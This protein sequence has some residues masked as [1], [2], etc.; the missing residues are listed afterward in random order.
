MRK[1]RLLLAGLFVVSLFMASFL[2]GAEKTFATSWEQVASAGLEGDPINNAI[3]RLVSFNGYLY[4]S[5]TNP[6]DGAKVF[7]SSNGTTWTKVSADGF[8][9]VDCTDAILHVH[10]D[11]IYAGTVGASTPCSKLYKSINGTTWTQVGTDGFGDAGND[12]VTSMVTFNNQL[13]V[14]T[15]NGVTGTEI[16]RLEE[17]GTLT[18]V[19]SDGFGLDANS[20]TWA[21]TIFGGAIYAGV[22]QSSV[23]GQAQIWKSL[24]GSDWEKIM[25]GGFG[26][27]GNQRITTFFTFNG[28]LYAGLLNAVSG[29][30][31]WRSISDTSWEQVNGDG[32]G[33]SNNYWPG[34][35][36]AIINGTIYV[37]VR[38]DV[39]G[40]ELYLSTNG[41]TWTQEGSSGFGDVDNFALY[42]ITFD[43][44]IYLGISSGDGVEIWRTGEMGTLSLYGDLGEGTVGE[45]YF[46]A[47]WTENGT[48][49]MTLSV[50][51]GALPDGLTLNEET[52]EITG[53][54]TKAGIFTFNVTVLDS[55]SPQQLASG[56]FTIKINEVEEKVILPK[57]GADFRYWPQALMF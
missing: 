41:E 21:L 20:E 43:G 30:E 42:A 34:D 8:G 7:R 26:D 23:A 1:C 49:P 40:C 45:S 55:G 27:N 11:A 3:S 39:T 35:T 6:F 13:Y 38:N 15:M 17:N 24:N 25:D 54:P 31:I 33:D 44:R 48:S 18:Q 22:G 36:V 47:F 46:E 52:G 51:G 10:G 19:N 32:F 16:F 4:A 28:R 5:I 56:E 14:G 53:T 12:G 57:T 50:T 29:A 9:D 37:G 2:V